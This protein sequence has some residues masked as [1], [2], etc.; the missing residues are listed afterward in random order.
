MSD[1]VKPQKIAILFIEKSAGP[2][3]FRQYLK[4]KKLTNKESKLIRRDVLKQSKQGGLVYAA[5][6]EITDHGSEQVR[7]VNRAISR[8]MDAI[9]LFED[10]RLKPA[11]CSTR[12]VVIDQTNKIDCWSYVTDKGVLKTAPGRAPHKEPDFGSYSDELG[13]CLNVRGQSNTKPIHKS[14]GRA[15]HFY[16]RGMES[17][18][19]IIKFI[20][21]ACAVDNLAGGEDKACKTTQKTCSLKRLYAK[22]HHDEMHN[23]IFRAFKKRHAI[24]HGNLLLD[25]ATLEN[26]KYV[27]HSEISLFRRLFLDAFHALLPLTNHH[28]TLKKAWMALYSCSPNYEHS[29]NDGV[30]TM[31]SSR[32]KVNITYTKETMDVLK[33]VASS[34]LNVISRR[35]TSAPLYP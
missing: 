15:L 12:F 19:N 4:F 35:T 20:F 31:I 9:S 33:H 28:T 29:S 26:E 8:V 17:E 3:A 24:F 32:H 7:M 25:E 2:E 21:I 11:A 1:T 34:S 18:E 27:H 14:L 13:A 10:V 22:E 23:K 6:F 16:R 5:A 30:L